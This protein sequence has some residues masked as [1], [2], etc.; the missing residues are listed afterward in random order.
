VFFVNLFVKISIIFNL[1]CDKVLFCMGMK[2]FS[3]PMTKVFYHS[4]FAFQQFNQINF[5][6]F[7]ED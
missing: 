5:I 3:E 1:E 7:W 4:S 6:D 2:I